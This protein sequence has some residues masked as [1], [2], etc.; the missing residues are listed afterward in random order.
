[1]IIA[2]AFVLLIAIQVAVRLAGLVQTI[3]WIKRIQSQS[4]R[5]ASALSSVRDIERI[6]G[7]I[8]GCCRRLP[9]HTTC[10]DCSLVTVAIL[11]RRL[12]PVTLCV[13]FRKDDT[14]LKGHAWVE[15]NARPLA[16]AADVTAMSRIVFASLD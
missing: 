4:V 10:L 3:E 9:F 1:M 14:D 6:A 15:H 8:R 5:A 2:E 12:V 16:E 11:S 13:G 7:L